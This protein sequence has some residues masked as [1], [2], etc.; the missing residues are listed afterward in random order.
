M[1]KRISNRIQYQKALRQIR[2]AGVWYIDIPRTSSSSIKAELQQSFG[3]AYGKSDINEHAYNISQQILPNH[4]TARE[5]RDRLNPV[6]WE[7]LFT[8]AF[9]RNPWDRLLS[10]YHYRSAAGEIQVQSF[11]SYL[12]LFFESASESDA[13][14]YHYHG[15]YYQCVDYIMDENGQL[16][17]DYVGRYENR[18][19]DLKQ[20]K[21]INPKLDL[22]KLHLN[23]SDRATSYR[24]HYNHQS[25]A[26][27]ATIAKRDIEAFGY[28]F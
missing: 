4:L 23:K 13:S 19:S 20:L 5:M 27:V 16:M 21:S 28:E 25:Q 7:R 2:R 10:L 18:V 24:E 3:N 11:Q 26:L 22:G 8:F 17:V 1:W 12:E 15:H 14:P 6:V 9:I